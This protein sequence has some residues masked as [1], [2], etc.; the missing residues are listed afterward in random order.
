MP[1]KSK[2]GKQKRHQMKKS[3]RGQTRKRQPKASGIVS[4]GFRDDAGFYDDDGPEIVVMNPSGSDVPLVENG[5]RIVGTAQAMV[6]YAK[7]L[8]DKAESE[9]DFNKG[10]MLT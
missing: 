4:S 3:K 8:L 9:E 7:P 2:K 10:F 1:K 5:Y 6:D